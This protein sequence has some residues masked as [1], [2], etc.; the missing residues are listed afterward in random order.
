MPLSGV[1]NSG[2]VPIPSDPPASG[3]PGRAKGGTS[4]R[5]ELRPSDIPPRHTVKDIGG[6]AVEPVNISQLRSV[7]KSGQTQTQRE[8][9]KATAEKPSMLRRLFTGVAGFVS[10]AVGGIGAGLYGAGALVGSVAKVFESAPPVAFVAAM[11][12]GI[13]GGGALIAAGIVGGG[14]AGAVHGARKG[15]FAEAVKS[16][17]IP[18]NFVTSLTSD[19]SKTPPAKD[20]PRSAST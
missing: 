11:L 20:S 8:A 14:V 5:A 17:A 1:N 15:T 7:P 18:V 12:A 2:Y 6:S 19:S 13:F 16:A 9:M 4:P 10:G 3:S